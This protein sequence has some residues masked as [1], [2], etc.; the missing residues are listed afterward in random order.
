MRLTSGIPKIQITIIYEENV[1]LI[2]TRPNEYR[3]LMMLIYDRISNE[4]F[5]ECLG[6][7][8]C[9]T[10]IVEILESQKPFN[11]LERNEMNTLSKHG[12][13]N[14]NIRLSCQILIDEQLDGLKINVI[15]K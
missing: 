9:A 14:K 13:S 15:A 3:N 4:E 5:G 8:K 6:M 7:G 1:Y 12:I 10:C 11:T 2:N